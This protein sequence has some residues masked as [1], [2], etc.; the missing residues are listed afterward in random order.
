MKINPKINERVNNSVAECRKVLVDATI[1]L[2]KSIGAETGQDVLFTKTLFLFQH[3]GNTT[4]TVVCDRISFG[5]KE[6]IPFLI[7]SMGEAGMVKSS[8]FMPISTLQAIYEEVREV[9]REY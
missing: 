4:E 7:V 8:I 6:E 2:L 5:P 9:V 1:E 3:K